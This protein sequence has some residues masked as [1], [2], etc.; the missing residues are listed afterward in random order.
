MRSDALLDAADRLSLAAIGYLAA[1][2]GG[3]RGAAE[4]ARTELNDAYYHYEDVK[5]CQA[6]TTPLCVKPD[7]KAATRAAYEEM[8]GEQEKGGE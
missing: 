3:T 4:R 2:A 7:S 1:T 6:D 5:F 8:T